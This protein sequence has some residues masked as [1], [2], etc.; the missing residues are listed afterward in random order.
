MGAV[1][2][3]R[4]SHVCFAD[5]RS[6]VP[7]CL[8]LPECCRS[9]TELTGWLAAGDPSHV[10]FARAVHVENARLLPLPMRQACTL[11]VLRGDVW[12]RETSVPV[13]R[14]AAQVSMARLLCLP[15]IHPPGSR[16][17]VWGV[18]V[19]SGHDV[20]ETHLHLQCSKCW[21]LLGC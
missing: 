4:H 12:S 14:C 8:W 19:A 7:L 2:G 18:V 6:H 20:R 17:S 13:Q 21:A 1:W 10:A 3:A 9:R 15:L 5:R 16:L 11:V